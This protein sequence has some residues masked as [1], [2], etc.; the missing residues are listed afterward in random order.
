[1]EQPRAHIPVKPATVLLANEDGTYQVLPD[2]GRGNSAPVDGV[3][4]LLSTTTLEPGDRVV[5]VWT[6]PGEPIPWILQTGDGG[7]SA[8][9][10]G[11]NA[12]G[13]YEDG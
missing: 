3:R 7:G 6:R 10:I 1:V 4:P 9:G 13:I 2:S 5:L 11:L 12:F 8:C